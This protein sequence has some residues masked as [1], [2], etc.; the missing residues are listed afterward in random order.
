MIFATT[1]F[2]TMN[3]AAMILRVSDPLCASKST[4]G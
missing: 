4:P 1:I 3:F 2:A